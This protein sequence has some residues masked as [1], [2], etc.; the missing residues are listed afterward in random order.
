MQSLKHELECEEKGMKE[1][2]LETKKNLRKALADVR[3]AKKK[4]QNTTI[5]CLV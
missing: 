5:R 4:V 2:L 1:N 3:T